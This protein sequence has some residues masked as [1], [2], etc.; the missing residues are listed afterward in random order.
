MLDYVETY[1]FRLDLEFWID[2]SLSILSKELSTYLD[3]VY[4]EY[5]LGVIND[6]VISTSL[7]SK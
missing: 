6:K 5:N 3:S 2:Y 7:C 1:W 4:K